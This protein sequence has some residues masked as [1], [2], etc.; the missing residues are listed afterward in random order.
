L[1]DL[2]PHLNEELKAQALQE[3]LAA[4]REI[5]DEQ[6]RA[7]AW[8]ALAP[9]LNDELKAQALQEALAAAREINGEDFRASALSDLAPH[10][11]N[12]LQITVLN[13]L[14]YLQDYLGRSLLGKAVETWKEIEFKG[15]KENIIP[16]LNFTSQKDRKKGVEVVG[17]LTPALVHF[18]GADITGELLRTITD[19]TRWWP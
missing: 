6:W 9:Y 14:I 16:F 3:A 13:D 1:S 15:L 12:E 7:S 18:C 19:V 4:A 11:G 10:L 5:K 8:S 2:T 17:F